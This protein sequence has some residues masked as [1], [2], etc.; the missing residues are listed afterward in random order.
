MG[1]RANAQHMKIFSS[2]TRP[3]A[4]TLTHFFVFFLVLLFAAP[5]A[6]QEP[7]STRMPPTD[8]LEA[9]RPQPERPPLP[10]P[11]SIWGT[12]VSRTTPVR[13]AAPEVVNLLADQPG[14]FLYDLGTAGWPHGWSY[15]G[16]NPNRTPLTLDGH[17]FTDLLTD[18]P[19]FDLLP[20]EFLQS[21]RLG[22]NARGHAFSAQTRF[23]DYDVERP[24]TELRFRR[25][26][27]GMQRVGVAHA[28]QRRIDWGDTPGFFQV[29]VG[30][31]GRG[32]DGEYLNSDIRR[33][34]R[35]LGRLQ[36][37]TPDWSVA[38]TDL[39]TRRRIGAHGG[40]LPTG[41]NFLTVYNPA[42]ATVRN[43]S[44]RRQTLRNDLTLTARSRLFPFTAAPLTASARWTKQTFRFRNTTDTLAAR[45]DS[46][47]FF[48]RQDATWGRHHITAKLSGTLDQ[49]IHGNAI[50][51]APAGRY[52]LHGVVRD[53]IRWN[54]TALALHTGAHQAEDDVHPSA[55]ARIER[56]WNGFDVF[57]SAALG[58]QPASWV[59]QHGF[60]DLI[61][62]PDAA[63]TS[64]IARA[65][66]GVSAAG[67]PFDAEL[68]TF[69]HATR[70]AVDLF[71]PAQGDTLVVRA[72]DDPLHR[73]GIA[74]EVGWRRDAE[75]GLYA[76]AQGTATQLLND[77]A[78][79]D[80]ARLATTLPEAFGQAR[81]GARFVLFEGDL[82][83][84]LSVRGRAWT[85]MRSRQF[86]GPT[87]LFAVSPPDAPVQSGWPM[88]FGPSGTVDVQADVGF[89]GATLFF[90][91]EN[92]LSGT[93]LQPGT[94]VVPVYPLPER[95]FRF[96]VFW[97]IEN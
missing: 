26:S 6:A 54:R 1:A 34:R 4:H 44:A 92:V 80:H 40:V 62:P 91:F 29:A 25:N 15:Q 41:S 81:I 84:D 42:I 52:R 86:H 37:R 57:A 51:P 64:R 76:T 22:A 2:P 13:M 69:G 45:T 61:L 50:D 63:P 87:A 78:S 12:P 93:T 8:S 56:R 97:P 18:R 43:P 58:G 5:A 68:T 73:A 36:Y 14:T 85:E 30:Y 90:T 49:W 38:L 9:E 21:P 96:G 59:E 3:S 19:R 35:L 53:S 27:N 20:I 23:R 77:S 88:A 89:R 7:D 74:A 39:H 75:R 46:Y 31:F 33:E 82:D 10:F 16:L 32:S 11:T 66:V 95:R 83:T 70:D 47:S 67:G 17:P 55:R 24:L 60:G 71:A 28:Q 65:E 79:P 72:L 48:L 94:F